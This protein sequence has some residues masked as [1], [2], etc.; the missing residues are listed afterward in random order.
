[1]TGLTFLAAMGF[2]NVWALSGLHLLLNSWLNRGAIRNAMIKL[3]SASIQE[4]ASATPG[5]S[6]HVQLPETA[7]LRENPEDSS[8]FNRNLI[9]ILRQA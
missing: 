1:M 3:V 6:Q 5:A 9:E 4:M 2:L 7:S 8:L